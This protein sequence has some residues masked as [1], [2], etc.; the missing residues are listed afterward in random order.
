MVVNAGLL[1]LIT[2]SVQTDPDMEAQFAEVFS[3]G[4]L[5]L[6]LLTIL[7][8]AALSVLA[9][10][11]KSA[12]INSSLV[13]TLGHVGDPEAISHALQE[14]A[15]EMLNI[16]QRELAS[17]IRSTNSYDMKTLTKCID[18]LAELLSPSATSA[19][20]S[21]HISTSRINPSV[22]NRATVSDRDANNAVPLPRLSAEADA[23]ATE[24]TEATGAT[25]ATEAAVSQASE[26]ARTEETD[27]RKMISVPL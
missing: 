20:A 21:K 14:C 6:I 2:K 4:I 15:V 8:A 25:G 23:K 27:S 18:L 3:I 22:M 24:A 12:G 9:L 5:M 10:A 16:S 26:A 19:L 1:L 7:G 11:L 13:L 17:K